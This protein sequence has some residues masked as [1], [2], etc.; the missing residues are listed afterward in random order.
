MTHK[1]SICKILF[2]ELQTDGDKKIV[3]S[4]L[5]LVPA[6]YGQENEYDGTTMKRWAELFDFELKIVS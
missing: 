6:I 3:M 1:P 2:T 5:N 4:N